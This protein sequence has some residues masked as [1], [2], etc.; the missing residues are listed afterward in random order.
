[1]GRD[2][3]LCTEVLIGWIGS[4]LGA[5]RTY[6][7][8]LSG[9]GDAADMRLRA[10]GALRKGVEESSLAPHIGVAIGRALKL[11]TDYLPRRSSGFADLFKRKTGLTP[12][13]DLSC[14]WAL[15]VFALQCSQNGRLSNRHELAAGTPAAERFDAF[16]N[17]ISR[18]P[19]EL[20]AAYTAEN[21]RGAF[22]PIRERPIMTTGDGRCMILDPTFFIECVSVA[23]SSRRRKARVEKDLSNSFRISVTLS[24]TMRPISSEACIHAGRAS[25]TA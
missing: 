17:L 11:F 18:T 20:K 19:E 25:S 15:L 9:P 2:Q 7:D 3:D 24:R 5:A 13:A 6:R 23:H 8:T 12:R 10:M 21:L 16:I 14:A 4:T 22:Q 1:V